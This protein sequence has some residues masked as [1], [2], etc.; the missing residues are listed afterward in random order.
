MQF[1]SKICIKCGNVKKFLVGTERDLKSICGDC[2]D[3]NNQELIGTPKDLNITL[4][5]E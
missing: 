2:W 1:I 4:P 5:T 3:W